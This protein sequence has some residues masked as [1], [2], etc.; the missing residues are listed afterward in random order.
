M[1]SSSRIYHEHVESIILLDLGLV[2]RPCNTYFYCILCI[3]FNYVTS[4]FHCAESGCRLVVNTEMIG[5][6]IKGRSGGLI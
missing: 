5:K 1:W 6:D 4:N 2:P 3:L